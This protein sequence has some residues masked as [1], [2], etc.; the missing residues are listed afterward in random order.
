MMRGGIYDHLGGGFHRYST[1]D[2][3]LVPHFEK[4]LYDNAQLTRTYLHAWQVTG[5]PDYRRV[6]EETLDYVL[7]EMVSPEGGI[8]STQDADSE[9]E[10]GKFFLWTPTQIRAHLSP[11]DAEL[12][13]AYYGVTDRGNFREGGPGAN[14]LNVSRTMEEAASEA[15]VSP[16]T[17]AAVLHRGREALFRAR[18]Q[19]VRPGRDDKVLAEWNGL[20]IEALA[21]AGAAFERADYIAAAENAAAFVLE[22]MRAPGD[23]DLIRLHRTYKDAQAKLNAYLEDYAAM[24]L[25]FIVL[26]QATFDTRWHRAAFQMARTIRAMFHDPEGGAFFQTSADHEQLVARRKDFVDSAV[27][28]GNSLAA[29]LL[30]RLAALSGHPEYV[31][32]AAEVMRLMAEAMGAQPGAFGRLLAALDLYLHPGREVAIIGDP[33]HPSTRALL[34]EIRKRYLPDAVIALAPSG[35]AALN[36]ADEIPLLAGRDQV[37]GHPTAYVCRNFVCRLPVTEPS[38]LAVQLDEPA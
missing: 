6:V 21:E 24:G 18:A 28:S 9:G 37:G 27:P 30:L 22:Q 19:R 29:E 35:E 25:G 17:L 11:A 2:R 36:L 26:Y 34:A 14:I 8:R 20:M 38:Q 15:G 4:M 1:D 3:W 10:E 32:E 12:F 31:D 5:T 23:D 13:M 16:E 7:R 33:A